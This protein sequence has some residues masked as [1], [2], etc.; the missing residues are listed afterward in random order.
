METGT[1]GNI[2]SYEEVTSSAMDTGENSNT[3][4]L[5][6]IGDKIM[7]L[8]QLMGRVRQ[9]L[10]GDHSLAPVPASLPYCT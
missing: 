6:P 1:N 3:E 2:P 9:D 8:K 10:L 5:K 7:A 4:G